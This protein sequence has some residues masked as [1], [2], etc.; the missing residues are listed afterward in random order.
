MPLRLDHVTNA[1]KSGRPLLS[2]EICDEVLKI[3]T[4][5]LI[6]RMY[7]CLRIA[8]EVSKSLGKEDI[9]SIS[10]VYRILKKNG[11]ESYKPTVKSGLTQTIKDTR[12]AWC[13]AHR[14]IDWKTVVFTDETSV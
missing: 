7:S 10:T 12:Q 4:K 11:Y 8:E 2:Q 14:N 1:P 13:L 9:V 5:N 3:V 6:T